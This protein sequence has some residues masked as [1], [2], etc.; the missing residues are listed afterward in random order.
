MSP[1]FRAGSPMRRAGRVLGGLLRTVLG[2]RF[3]AR[4]GESAR[5][6]RDEY[7][8]G[9]TEG[10]PPSSSVKPAPHRVV[11]EPDGPPDPDPP[12]G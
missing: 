2:R 7:R 6:L 9:K 5:A 8:A 12:P 4:L 1:T 11:E 10:T 3:L